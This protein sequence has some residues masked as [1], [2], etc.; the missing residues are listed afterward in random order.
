VVVR[1]DRVAARVSETGG[2]CGHTRSRKVRGDGT[3]R[4]PEKTHQK[5]CG[6][7]FEN[8]PMFGDSIYF[9]S[10]D[11]LGIRIPRR[12]TGS[13]ALAPPMGTRFGEGHVLGFEAGPR[14]NIEALWDDGRH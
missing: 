5:R 4:A 11:L 12:T 1:F 7:L 10:S 9:D 6:S 13:T 2:S 8:A 3:R 14:D